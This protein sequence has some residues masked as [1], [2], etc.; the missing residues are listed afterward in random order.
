[1]VDVNG[2][3]SGSAVPEPGKAAFLT[4]SL[5]GLIFRRRRTV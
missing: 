3:L 5:M 4:L 2:T 1:M